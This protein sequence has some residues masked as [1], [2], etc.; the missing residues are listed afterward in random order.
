MISIGSWS[1]GPILLFLNELPGIMYW[2]QYLALGHISLL[3]RET[4]SI[5]L[6]E[7]LNGSSYIGKMT[8]LGQGRID[9]LKIK[10]LLE[11]GSLEEV[12]GNHYHL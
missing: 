2:K 4:V 1:K 10:R 9:S 3:E 11:P 8:R 12:K 5:F 6:L 7:G